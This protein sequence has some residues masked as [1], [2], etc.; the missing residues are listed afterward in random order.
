MESIDLLKNEKGK[1]S[2]IT[3]YLFI[4]VVLNVNDYSP[5]QWYHPSVSYPLK[6]TKYY[7]KYKDFFVK[8]LKINQ[9]NK[10]IIV[11]NGLEHL[12]TSTF[13]ANCFKKTK[14]SEITFRF[15]IKKDCGEFG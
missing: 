12:L 8:K 5:N 10:I 13:N 6:N 4:P 15:E 3:D 7:D 11:G 9:I 14:L 2:V 1:F